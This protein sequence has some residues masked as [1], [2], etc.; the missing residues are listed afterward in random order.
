MKRVLFKAVA[1]AV[2][3]LSAASASAL[4]RE[5]CGEP[6]AKF[7]NVGFVYSHLRQGDYP[8]LHSDFG[9]SLFKGRTYYMHRPIAGMMRFGIDAVWSDLSY[10]NYKVNE[11][12]PQEWGEEEVNRFNIHEVGIGMQVGPSVTVNLCKRLQMSA[13]FRYNPTLQCFYAD[14]FTAG[15]GNMFTGG[16]SLNYGVVGLGI[17]T[18]FGKSKTKRLFNFGSGGDDDDDNEDYGYDDEEESPA[19]KLSSRL[20]SRL[21]GLRAYICLRF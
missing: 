3:L 2:M 5:E 17:E 6:R 1:A 20:T 19:P 21:S 16:F 15:F 7:T 11:H 9:A 12:Y 10:V 13:Y 18:R 8:K 4:D 14:E